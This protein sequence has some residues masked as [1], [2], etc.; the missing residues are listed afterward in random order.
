M[1]VVDEFTCPRTLDSRNQNHVKQPHS[2]YFESDSG[3]TC[4]VKSTASANPDTAGLGKVKPPARATATPQSPRQLLG[5]HSVGRRVGM[6]GGDKNSSIPRGTSKL[7]CGASS[8]TSSAPPP[9]LFCPHYFPS[10]C[11]SL[12]RE[13]GQTCH[14]LCI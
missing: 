2:Y 5:R 10:S 4:N 11:S 12:S 14:K 3:C 1:P 8:P 6:E 7:N 13:P 9:L